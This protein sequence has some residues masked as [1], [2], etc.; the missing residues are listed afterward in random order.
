MI[1]LTDENISSLSAHPRIGKVAEGFDLLEQVNE[2]VTDKNG[3]PIQ[4]IRIHHTLVI[5]DPFNPDD[6]EASYSP[7]PIRD[8]EDLIKA[9]KLS[10]D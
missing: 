3:V 6:Q 8:T 7:S 2:V 4:N 10:E 9:G 5:D 1:C